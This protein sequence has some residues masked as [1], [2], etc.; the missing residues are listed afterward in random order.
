M[1]F[2]PAWSE[3]TADSP[4]QASDYYQ[5]SYQRNAPYGGMSYY[6]YIHRYD[7][8]QRRGTRRY[9]Q[10]ESYSY[11]RNYQQYPNYYNR[12]QADYGGAGSSDYQNRRS[13]NRYKQENYYL[14]QRNTQQTQAYTNS[15]GRDES[16]YGGMGYNAYIHR[17]DNQ[18]K[19][20]RSSYRRSPRSTYDDSDSY[21]TPVFP[22]TQQRLAERYRGGGARGS[23]AYRP[24][25]KAMEYCAPGCEPWNM[26]GHRDDDESCHG[27]NTA[28]DVMAVR[29]GGQ[30][31]QMGDPKF[32]EV[33][34]CMRDNFHKKNGSFVIWHQKLPRSYDYMSYK[35][36]RAYLTQR[37]WDHFH[38]SLG[39]SIPGRPGY[40]NRINYW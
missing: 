25:Q 36:Q 32:E 9:R 34:Q 15:S 6:D 35:Q 28:I 26:G 8:Q 37:H 2:S 33:G 4:W 39:C 29:C 11:Q 38:F 40:P 5:N 10:E 21:R 30:V 1:S 16:V 31:Y 12:D 7:G 17:Y 18:Q 24:L 19:Q 22:S 27:Y 23:L 14:N 20:A 13:L 3:T